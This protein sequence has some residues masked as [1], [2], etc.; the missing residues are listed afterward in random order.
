MPW[1]S[2]CPQNNHSA[3]ERLLVMMNKTNIYRES[4]SETLPGTVINEFNFTTTTL[5]NLI[6]EKTK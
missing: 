6:T 5:I 3:W 4:T 1:L 2:P